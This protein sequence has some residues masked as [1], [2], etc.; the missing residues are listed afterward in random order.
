MK[1][2]FYAEKNHNAIS[3]LHHSRR[4]A[5]CFRQEMFFVRRTLLSVAN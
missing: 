5:I 1:V 3:P 4:L 2:H